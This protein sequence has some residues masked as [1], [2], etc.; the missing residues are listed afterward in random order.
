MK[1][2]FEST[3]CSECTLPPNHSISQIPFKDN[4]IILYSVRCRDC[5]DFWEESYVKE[6][7]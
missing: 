7:S 4:H 3:I 6:N 2:N 1:S 5:N